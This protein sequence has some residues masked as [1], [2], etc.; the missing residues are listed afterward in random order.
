MINA[1]ADIRESKGSI[2]PLLYQSR[3]AKGMMYV[4][5]LKHTKM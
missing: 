1:G 3:E 2:D 5:V 4:L